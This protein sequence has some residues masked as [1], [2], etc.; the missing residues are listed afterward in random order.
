MPA[1]RLQCA[2][3][4]QLQHSRSHEASTVYDEHT[5]L[6]CGADGL[7]ART[8]LAHHCAVDVC[9]QATGL[10]PLTGYV[11]CFAAVDTDGT[12]Q[13]EATGL[14]FSTAD[15]TPPVLKIQVRADTLAHGVANDSCSLLAEA[16]LSE[17][18]NAR[19]YA[20]LLSTAP[21]PSAF[22]PSDLYTDRIQ[23][24]T[25]RFLLGSSVLTIGV[26]EVNTYIGTTMRNLPCASHVQV[27]S[28]CDEALPSA[29]W[30]RS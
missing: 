8:Q 25:G 12:A 23:D 10:Q 18:G 27:W 22:A 28:S 29:G 19:L 3:L 1:R 13:A 21:D 20:L 2:T 15:T 17:V 14:A 30:A 4:L 26:S 7:R 11:A 16:R 5:A 6:S 24:E 9:R